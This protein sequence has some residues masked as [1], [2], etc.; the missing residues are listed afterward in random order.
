MGRAELII[1]IERRGSPAAPRFRVALEAL[2]PFRRAAGDLFPQLLHDFLKRGAERVITALGEDIRA[3]RDEVDVYLK[4]RT[5]VLQSD[6]PNIGFVNLPRATESED[7]FL[8]PG[9]QGG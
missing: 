1:F 8:H 9:I 5:R 7:L 6:Q 4:G 2:Q 3:G